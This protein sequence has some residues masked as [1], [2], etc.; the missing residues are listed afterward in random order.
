[1]NKNN[2]NN[3]QLC[4]SIKYVCQLK[5]NEFKL[6]RNG[7]TVTLEKGIVMS[8][9]SLTMRCILNRSESSMRYCIF[10]S[11]FSRSAYDINW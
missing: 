7:Y 1:M 10:P 2:I 9:D 4:V 8:Q 5:I 6:Y 11:C 3:E